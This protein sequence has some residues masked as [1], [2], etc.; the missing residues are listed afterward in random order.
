M[1]LINQQNP[2]LWMR[3]IAVVVVV[4]AILTV[5]FCASVMTVMYIH[6]DQKGMLPAMFS[7]NA[8]ITESMGNI[9]PPQNV[10]P[11]DSSQDK[12]PKYEI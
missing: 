5:S 8:K 12:A 11:H 2:G 6:A 10:V 4:I 1:K 9:L 3:G 7:L